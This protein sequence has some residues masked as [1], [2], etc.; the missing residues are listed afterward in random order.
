MLKTKKEK[1]YAGLIAVLAIATLCVIIFSSRPRQVEAA[2]LSTAGTET[3]REV[4]K[5]IPVEK[6]VHI[7]KEITADI[8]QD[9]LRDM[10]KL[11]T[12]EYYFTEVVSFSSVKQLFKFDL[13]FTESSYLASYDG[14][15]TAGIDFTQIRVEKDG[16]QITVRLPKADVQNVDIDPNSFTL[17]SEKSGVGN[18]V[19]VTDFN[20]S[21]V[22]LEAN[23]R[24]KAID[25]GLLDRAS[26]NA[27]QVLSNF[28][29]GLMADTA[30]TLTVL[31]G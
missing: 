12:E 2:P 8:V 18:P 11:I 17:H 31:E 15:V 21:L 25:R 10:G 16:T 3:V 5:F 19:S 7:E 1:F 9:G 28:V 26:D 20:A 29:S 6:I 4:N 30:Y 23:A 27:K 14:V 22:E 13:P 24:Q